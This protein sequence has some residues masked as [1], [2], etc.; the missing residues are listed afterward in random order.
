MNDI[1][2]EVVAG[3]ILLVISGA[4]GLV[5]FLIRRR[6]FKDISILPKSNKRVEGDSYVHL[7][8]KWHLYWVS[9]AS[10]KPSEPLWFHGIQELQVEKNIVRGT[11]EFVDHPVLNLYSNLQGEIRA[12]NMIVV[13][14][15]SGD[16]TEF[17]SVIYPNLRSKTLLVGIWNGL[18]NLLR[19]IAAPAVLSRKEL[20]EN[21][22]NV[23]LIQ[24]PMSLIPA[25]EYQLH[26]TKE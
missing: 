11:T 20:S 4:S 2:T 3:I 17:A 16:E 7:N 6:Y 21:E 10:L 1:M 25:G 23:I 9:F 24:S 14:T 15:Y 5:G 13:D 26:G 12:G 18:D 19:P 8:G 22:L